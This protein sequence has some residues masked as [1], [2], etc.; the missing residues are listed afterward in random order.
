MAKLKLAGAG[1]TAVRERGMRAASGDGNIPAWVSL[2]SG[3]LSWLALP[4]IG[5]IVAI[6]SGHRGRSKAKNEGAPHGGMALVGLLLGY[7][8]LVLGLLGIAA[9]LMLPG[10]WV[11]LAGDAL[12]EPAAITQP[13]GGGEAVAVPSGS[14]GVAALD[15]SKLWVAARMSK[16]MAL[17]EITEDFPLEAVHREFWQSIHIYQGTIT[18]VPVGGSEDQPLILLSMMGAD[19][20]L[21]WVCG[22]TVPA[23][24]EA[25]C[26]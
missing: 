10:L 4:V 18:A 13:V 9:A 26:Q 24:A 23:F 22:G 5:S 12:P 8:S 7:I 17:N 15:A 6:I 11:G 1:N 25:A 19:N 2:I 21:V 14:G 20:K 3:V 16:G